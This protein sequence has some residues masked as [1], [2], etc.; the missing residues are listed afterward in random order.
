ME[1]TSG[2]EELGSV[3]VLS[4]VS[5]GE[6]TRLGMLQLEVFVWMGEHVQVMIRTRYRCLDLPANFSP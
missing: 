6:E 1:R 3:G 5:H 2:D 4:G